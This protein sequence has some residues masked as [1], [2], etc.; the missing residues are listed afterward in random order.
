MQ[1]AV[2]LEIRLGSGLDRLI[3]ERMSGMADLVYN[4]ADRQLVYNNTHLAEL[5]LEPVM[6][7]QV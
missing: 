1:S 5:K 7:K 2:A 6:D 3:L 4:K